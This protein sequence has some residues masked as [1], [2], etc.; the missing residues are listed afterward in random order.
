MHEGLATRA[1]KDKLLELHHLALLYG[2]TNNAE[3]R[4]TDLSDKV[5]TKFLLP[6]VAFIQ[7]QIG[8]VFGILIH[9]RVWVNLESITDKF[10]EKDACQD[11]P[12]VHAT[13][14][15]QA[16]LAFEEIGL[17]VDI[18]VDLG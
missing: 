14:L 16:V 17:L 5:L 10:K 15:Q 11:F 7:K 8:V 12:E 2:A 4:L 3:A 1:S 13:L 6:F 18:L 9:D